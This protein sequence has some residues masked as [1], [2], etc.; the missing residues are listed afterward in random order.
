MAKKQDCVAVRTAKA[1]GKGADVNDVEAKAAGHIP[2]MKPPKPNLFTKAKEAA[3]VA[4]KKEKGT[5][6]QL[7]KELD[8]EGRLIGDSAL[9]NNAVTE[10]LEASS[11]EKAAKNKGNLAK[12]RLSKYAQS[13]VV[14][15]T[16]KLG[17][18]PPTPV[19]VVNHNGESVT[20]VV[21]DKSQQ[22]AIG[23]EQ[24][25]L[26]K[27]VLGEDGAARVVHTKTTFAF[28]VNTME[29]KAANGNA[30]VAEIVAEVVSAALAND[31]RLS[32][33]QKGALITSTEKTYLRP[34]TLQRVA[35]LCGADAA[36]IDQ[37]LEAAGSAVVRY[38]K[39]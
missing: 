26:F 18:L 16:A 2:L 32:D 10:V 15:L 38:V 7:P 12:G 1:A 37:F 30:S 14:Q 25:E 9:L 36:R 33:E 39:S 35:E 5:V 21:Q 17:V 29:E 4:P 20:Y 23:P 3:V 31:K 22:N 27:S 8:V 19:S 28:D 6:L 11:E 34:N 24:V 13:Q